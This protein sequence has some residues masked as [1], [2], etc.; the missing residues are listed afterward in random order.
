[1]IV[2]D[3]RM[4]MSYHAVFMFSCFKLRANHFSSLTG[5]ET[6]QRIMSQGKNAA[7]LSDLSFETKSL[8]TILDY[9]YSYCHLLDVVLGLILITGTLEYDILHLAYLA[10]A[11][12]FSRMRLEILKKKNKIFK[13]LRLYNF[14]LIVLSLAH[15]S[16]FLGYF[17][18]GKSKTIGYISKEFDYVSKYLEAEQNG[19]ILRKQEKKAAW[20][21]A[22]LQHI[23]K[24]EEQKRLRNMQVEKMKSEMLSLQIWL[25]KMGTTAHC[26]DTSPQSKG[27][28]SRANSFSD[29]GEN[30]FN[31]QNLN[32][33]SSDSIF[34]FDMIESPTVE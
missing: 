5:S 29:K 21:T 4:L 15:Q 33:L 20:K 8:W 27:L 22:Q 14:V 1:M 34:S 18:E 13:F 28:E 30:D 11:L 2:D 17:S 26:C 12:I 31:K 16:P 7:S 24:Y 23:L 19:A 32:L 6:Y 10:F 25:H 3:P 9:L